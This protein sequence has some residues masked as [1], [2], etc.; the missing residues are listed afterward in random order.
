[1]YCR[2]CGTEIPDDTLPIYQIQR[3]LVALI[4]KTTTLPALKTLPLS[5]TLR[6]KH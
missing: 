2:K 5:P 6:R 3:L 4:F 1:M